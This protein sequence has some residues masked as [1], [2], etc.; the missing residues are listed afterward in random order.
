MRKL[1]RINPAPL[2]TK[3]LLLF[4]LII[5]LFA[6]SIPDNKPKI[7]HVYVALCDNINQGII[8]VSERLGNGEDPGNNLYW[9]A[10]YG[11]KT[12]FKNSDDWKLLAALKNPQPDVLERCLFKSLEFNAFL[13]ADAYRGKSI[14]K[15]ISDFLYATAGK[16]SEQ[17]KIQSGQNDFIIDAGGRSDLVAY[18]GHNGL[19]DFSLEEYPK[20]NNNHEREVIILACA[21]KKHFFDPIRKSGAY[22]LIWTTALLAPE[23]YSLKSALTG[24]LQ[25]KSGEAVLNQTARTYAKF[26]KCSLKAAEKLFASG[27]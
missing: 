4:I 5:T 25:E 17:I 18:V 26:Q 27:W 19:M 1:Q 12:H 15:T 14:K 24:W 9:G 3:A 16:A 21:S 23:A 22:P 11:V 2:K 7:I 20:G 13:V 10:F 8:P 6:F